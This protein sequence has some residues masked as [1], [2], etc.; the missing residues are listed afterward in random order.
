MQLLQFNLKK[1]DKK[2]Q[3]CAL[4]KQHDVIELKVNTVLRHSFI[5]GRESLIVLL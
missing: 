4:V 1:K 5:S 2:N 3:I